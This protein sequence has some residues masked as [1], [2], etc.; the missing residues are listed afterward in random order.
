MSIKSQKDFFSGL[1]FMGIG[2]AFAWG[3]TTY[4]VGDAA[5]MGPGYFLLWLGILMLVVVLLPAI[6][7]KREEAFVEESGSGFD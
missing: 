5:R 2:V 6:K 4:Q 3:A 1:M 7:N